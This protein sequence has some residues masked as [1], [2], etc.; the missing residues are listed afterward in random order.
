MPDLQHSIFGRVREHFPASW[1]PITCSKATLVDFSHA[2]EDM[3]IIHQLR[4]VLLTGF[5]ESA[6]W[7]QEIERYQR[8]SQIAQQVCIFAGR[9]LPPDSTYGEVR[10]A[11]PEGSPLRQEWFVIGLTEHFSILLAGLDRLE[12]AEHE[13]LRRFETLWTFD[14]DVI[15]SALA[16]LVEVVRQTRPDKARQIEEALQCFPPCYPQAHYASL[17][18]QKFLGHLEQQHLLAHSAI[19]HL[20]G[21]VEIRT[22][23]LNAARQLLERVLQ[24][25]SSAVIVL[26]ERANVVISNDIGRLL[27][28]GSWDASGEYLAQLHVALAE[29]VQQAAI[30]QRDLILGDLALSLSS[31]RL[32]NEDGALLTVVVLHD[33]SQ[34]YWFDQTRQSLLEVLSHQLRTPLTVLNNAIYLIERDPTRLSEHLSTLR[35]STQRLVSLVNNL[36]EVA[37]TQLFAASLLPIYVH[38]VLE[39]F[40]THLGAQTWHQRIKVENSLQRR[41][42]VQVDLK[43]F[44][45][46][47]LDVLDCLQERL[48]E[49]ERIHMRIEML[50]TAEPELWLSIR[51]TD[52]GEPLPTQETTSLLRLASQPTQ[53]LSEAMR[54]ALRLS[55]ARRIIQQYRGQLIVHNLPEQVQVHI[56]IPAKRG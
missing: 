34:L 52:L 22:R 20:D 53:A 33:L 38:D 39:H 18:L 11:L 31:S 25:L 15:G 55:L 24:H 23:Q 12:P 32:E 28:Q 45:F 41:L 1:Q 5:Q 6:Y 4:G 50:G 42:V 36:L 19:L 47:L 37:E 2:I 17:L 7:N 8:I 51:L 9:P 27:L 49:T 43:R 35:L 21:L 10:V 3:F 54:C 56:L 13:A 46:C 16:D 40:M 29:C 30:Y 26:D 48:A 44:I 14:P